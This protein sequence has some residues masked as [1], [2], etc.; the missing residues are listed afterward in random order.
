MNIF[1]R[2]TLMIA[3][4]TSTALTAVNVNAGIPVFDGAQVAQT[5]VNVGQAIKTVDNTLKTAKQV[6][7]T[8]DSVVG[9]RNIGALFNNP[10]TNKYLPDS[11]KSSWGELRDI[12]ALASTT[13]PRDPQSMAGALAGVADKYNKYH[14]G[15]SSTD[16][17]AIA[18]D[19][20]RA[21]QEAL[22]A[23]DKAYDAQ[24]GRLDN[25]KSLAQTIDVATDPKAAQDLLNRIQVE[26]SLINLEQQAQTNLLAKQAAHDQ[27]LQ[28]EAAKARSAYNSNT[29]K[30]FKSWN[31]Q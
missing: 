22:A 10:L 7:D 17:K 29:G 19:Q 3:L 5:I 24:K 14:T 21:K 9:N 12:Y 25:L 11:M 15:N 8:Y 16:R 23:I 31:I 20:A 27:M 4:A 18:D 6:K 30:D 13:N 28:Q 2:T 26:Q 1:K